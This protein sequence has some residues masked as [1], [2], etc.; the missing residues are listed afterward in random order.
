[1]A[2]IAASAKVEAGQEG[3]RQRRLR[4]RPRPTPAGAGSGK[5]AAGDL[6]GRRVDAH[7]RELER[8]GHGEHEGEDQPGDED[9]GGLHRIPP[10]CAADEREL[11]ALRVGADDDTVAAGHLRAGP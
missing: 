5:P 11:G 7:E 1:M 9:R 8:G 10:Y 3:D 2:T 6:G 4:K